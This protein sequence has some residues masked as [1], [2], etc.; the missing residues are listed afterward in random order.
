MSLSAQQPPLS[1]F[2]L[3]QKRREQILPA[4][5]RRKRAL[6]RAARATI[7]TGPD[8]GWDRKSGLL[9]RLRQGLSISHRRYF[10]K[11][12]M[13]DPCEDDAV[14]RITTRRSKSVVWWATIRL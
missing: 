6:R 3:R 11:S 8:R 1:C 7:P 14:I 4:A 5:A 2:P 13:S 12:A 9:Y 10:G